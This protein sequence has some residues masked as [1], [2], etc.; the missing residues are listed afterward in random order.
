MS[1][2]ALPVVFTT[3]AERHLE[4]AVAWWREHRPAAPN[5]ILDELE[6]ALSLL[7]LHPSI[8]AK[9]RSPRLPG[10]RRIL[11]E[12]VG[13]HLYYRVRSVLHRID[14]LALWHSRRG[15]GPKL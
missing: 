7:T 2:P 1:P 10:V 14:I 5:A 13:Y 11:L 3:R 15:E 4:E 8:G 6:R 9:A 12:T